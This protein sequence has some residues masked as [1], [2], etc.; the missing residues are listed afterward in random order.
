MQKQK[1]KRERERKRKRKE[2]EKSLM[3]NANFKSTYVLNVFKAFP[4]FAKKIEWNKFKRE[5]LTNKKRDF[6]R[7]ILHSL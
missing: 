3:L 4:G 5:R 2:K 6:S 7:I 1:K